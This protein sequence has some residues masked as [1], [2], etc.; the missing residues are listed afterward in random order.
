MT[1]PGRRQPARPGQARRAGQ[2]RLG[3]TEADNS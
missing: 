2:G 1:F 3:A